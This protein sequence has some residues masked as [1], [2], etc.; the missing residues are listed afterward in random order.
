VGFSI[1]DVNILYGNL[2]VVQYLPIRVQQ[3][4]KITSVSAYQCFNC[5]NNKSIV[6]LPLLTCKKEVIAPFGYLEVKRIRV[7]M[8]TSQCATNKDDI[9]EN[10]PNS[11]T[12]IISK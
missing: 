1:N 11:M 7:F 4:S 3:F 9:C 12:N 10:Y 2:D 6:L 8:D 5:S